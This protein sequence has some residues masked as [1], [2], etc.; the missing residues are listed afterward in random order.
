MPPELKINCSWLTE[1]DYCEYKFYRKY[2]L[3][4]EIPRTEAMIRGSF[5]HSAKEEKFLEVAEEATMEDLLASTKYTITKELKLGHEFDDFLLKGKIDEL[6]VDADNIYIIDDKPRAKPYPGTQRQIWS[7]CILFKKNFPAI[8]KTVHAVLRDRDSDME[9]WTLPF[10]DEH[11]IEVMRILFRIKRLF[12]GRTSPIPTTNPGRCKA[13]I[14]HK[15]Q[16][17]SYSVA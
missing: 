12:E 3:K 10:A 4:E 6:A 7:Y 16:R 1:I 11:G 17:C 5:V 2:V 13:C 15:L 9:V 8:N 14:L